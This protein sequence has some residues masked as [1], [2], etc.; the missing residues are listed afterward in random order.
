[1]ARHLLAG[2]FAIGKHARTFGNFG[3][4]LQ[5]LDFSTSCAQNMVGKTLVNHWVR[6]LLDNRAEGK[7]IRF[8]D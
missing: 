7:I 4:S 8:F 1:V 3:V 6:R 5:S 2:H